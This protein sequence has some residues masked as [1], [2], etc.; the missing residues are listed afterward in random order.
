MSNG[1]GSFT[2][3]V[4]KI[5]EDYTWLIFD[6]FLFLLLISLFLNYA[7][8]DENMKGILRGLLVM[9]LWVYVISGAHILSYLKSQN[10]LKWWQSTLF[11]SFKILFLVLYM[12][13]CNYHN[14][15][16]IF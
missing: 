3:S 8:F 11:Y 2:K 1:Q 7:S 14:Y 9:S 16:N 6:A 4:G 13:W 15:L 12:I 10:G 5:I